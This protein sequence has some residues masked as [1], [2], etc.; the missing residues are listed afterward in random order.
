MS[1]SIVTL[2]KHGLL[3]GHGVGKQFTWRD[4]QGEIASSINVTV[5]ME[6]E[7]NPSARFRY[8][9]KIDDMPQ[10]VDLLMALTPTLIRHGGRR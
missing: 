10:D 5:D 8:S 2:R 4:D 6:H 9:V 3:G 1:L 7:P